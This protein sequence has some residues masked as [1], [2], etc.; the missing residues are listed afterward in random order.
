MIVS[1]AEVVRVGV[2]DIRLATFTWNCSRFGNMRSRFFDLYGDIAIVEV[3]H[4][5]SSIVLFWFTPV[6]TRDKGRAVSQVKSRS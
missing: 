5:A 2:S 3:T 4:S 6:A 1:V